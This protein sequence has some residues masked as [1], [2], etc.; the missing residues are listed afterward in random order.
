MDS[1]STQRLIVINF[2]VVWNTEAEP[3]VKFLDH[4][5]LYSL[6]YPTLRT[7]GLMVVRRV[8]MWEIF[9][10]LVERMLDSV[11]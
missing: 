4:F 6:F 3:E 8:L 7:W 2:Q 5:E 9:I 10:C 11:K 1:F